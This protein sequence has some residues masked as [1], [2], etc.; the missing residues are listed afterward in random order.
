MSLNTIPE[1][2]EDIKSGKAVILVDD[3]DRENEGDLIIAADYITP[4]FVNFMAVEARGL[5][6]LSLTSGQIERL[7]L[8][9]MTKEE[10]NLSPNRTAFTVSIEAAKGV[11]TG[12]SAADRALTIK[13]ASNPS[14]HPRDII[15]PGH[16]FPIRAQEGGVLKRAGHTEASVDLARLAGLNP[17]AVICEI[18]NPDGTMARMGQLIEF[19]KKHG[20]KIGTIESLIRYRIQNESFLIERAQALLPCRYGKDFRIHVFENSLDGREHVVLVKGDINPDQPTLVRVHSECLMGDVFGSLRTRT[21]EYL[22]LSLKR[23]EEEGNGVLVY[24]RLEDMGQRLR[25]RVLSYH[26]MDQGEA[27]TEETRKAFRSDDRDYGIGAQIL[28]SLGIRQL[29]L[30]TNSHAK[31][32]GL[33]GYGLEIVEEVPLPIDTEP[34]LNVE[35]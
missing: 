23:I 34:L 17:A 2:I 20:I 14:A 27:P 31:R 19:A 29:R 5:I 30:I 10:S 7:G 11:S 3:E 22:D 4:Q 26:Q 6:C 12:I 16:V 8:P 28:R 1:L 24:L 21:G 18:M 13:V 32:V 35:D 25:Q 33:K 9:L 15:V